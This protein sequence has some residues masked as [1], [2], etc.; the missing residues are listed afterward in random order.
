MFRL[1][2]ILIIFYPLLS[3][4]TSAFAQ[5]KTLGQVLKMPDDTIKTEQLK[6]LA[7]GYLEQEKTDSALLCN[8]KAIDICNRVNRFDKLVDAFSNCQKIYSGIGNDIKAIDALIQ[9]LQE[10]K[11]VN[12][13]IGVSNTCRNF[14]IY[15]F[16][17]AQ[18][19]EPL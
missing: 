6:S 14:A 5:D 18:Y 12:Y 1:K 3:F 9:L 13:M 2:N 8:Q 7:E 17:K 16:G 19:H 4:L 10:C 11:A 15:Y